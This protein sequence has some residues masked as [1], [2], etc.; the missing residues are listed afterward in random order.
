[1]SY[2]SD[3]FAES[4]APVA[5]RDANVL[6]LGSFPG[7]ESLEA[8]RYYANPRN[9]FWKI[10]SALLGFAPD[11]PYAERLLALQ[12]SGIALWDVLHS[13]ERPGSLDTSIK[14]ESEKPNNFALFF[15]QHP[16]INA[17]FCNGAKAYAGYMTHVKPEEHGLPT[18][19][20][21]P[22]TSPAHASKT[23]AQKLVAWEV[24]TKKAPP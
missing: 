1:M 14:R 4:F 13:C 22:S 19:V 17:V 6:I 10:M 12:S 5:G 16:H 24:V 23:F 9:Q 7:L 15:R 11:T 21:L 18:A 2:M 8:G 3:D 20:C